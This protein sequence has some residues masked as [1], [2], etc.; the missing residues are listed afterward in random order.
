M[1]LLRR[2][3]KYHRCGRN[4]RNRDSRDVQNRL[5]PRPLGIAGSAKGRHD[6]KDRKDR[7][8]PSGHR[9]RFGPTG[10]QVWNAYIAKAVNSANVARFT[11]AND[12]VLTHIEADAVIPPGR[13]EPRC[14]GIDLVTPHLNVHFTS[15]IL[16]MR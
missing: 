1:R 13:P 3:L 5:A 11:P 16:H 6:R 14:S 12:I 7:L 8:A 2:G 10:S 15:T 9:V 4:G